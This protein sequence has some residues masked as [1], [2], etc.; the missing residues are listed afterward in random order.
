[1]ASMSGDPTLDKQ[2]AAMTV[3]PPRMLGDTDVGLILQYAER[4]PAGAAILE[5]GPWLGGLT[6]L[7]APF[8]QITVVDRF[9][10]SEANAKAYPGIAEPETSFR[11]VFEANMASAGVAVEIVES[12]LPDLVWDQRDLDLVVVDA[13]RDAGTLHG[14]LRAIAPSLK[15]GTRILVKHA[16]N[17]RDFGMGAYLDALA[18]FGY[19]SFDATEQP[20]WCNIAVATVT[21]K[22]ISIADF[23]EAD[24]LIAAAP[25]CEG[26]T[27]PWYGHRL[28]IFRLA[29]LATISRWQ[30]A[31]GLLAGMAPNSENLGLWDEIEAQIS[32]EEREVSEVA[33]SVLAALVWIHN[34]SVA[35][36]PW[37]LGVSVLERLRA[38]WH[39]NAEA[40]ERQSTLDLESLF[41]DDIEP[42]IL[43]LAGHVGL[44]HRK[45]VV[46]FSEQC[47]ELATVARMAGTSHIT[48]IYPA[49]FATFDDTTDE[50]EQPFASLSC[51]VDVAVTAIAEA[52]VIITDAKSRLSPEV[53]A[54]IKLRAN[55]ARE[56]FRTISLSD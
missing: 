17:P 8:G 29:Y 21:D 26:F 49:D 52:D 43:K 38:Y 36:A 39:N 48:C 47:K 25:V 11:S 45:T 3:Q 4:L 12:A 56:E 31:F 7:L 40:I 6:C 51:D 55:S 27:D 53:A 37:P 1:M 28:T 54:A 24:D 20:N 5:V 46:A 13:P 32:A 42:L 10:W 15:K 16:L 18:G 41:Q 19:I 9:I 33:L 2:T 35:A 14:C 23:A 44:L 30:D 22:T 34:D 50:R